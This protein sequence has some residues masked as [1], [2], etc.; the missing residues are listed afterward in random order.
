VAGAWHGQVCCK[1]TLFAPDCKESF[2]T[3]KYCHIGDKI[4]R[5][6]WHKQTLDKTGDYNLFLSICW[7]KS[8]YEDEFKKTFI[9][10]QLFSALSKEEDTAHIT[11]SLGVKTSLMATRKGH[12]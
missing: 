6:T 1:W 7:H 2:L 11:H 4:S 9:Q 8:F 3:N 5:H 10:A 12:Q